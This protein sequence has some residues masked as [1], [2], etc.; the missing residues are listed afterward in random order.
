ML[1]V[2]FVIARLTNQRGLLLKGMQE[3]MKGK[4]HHAIFLVH[5]GLSLMRRDTH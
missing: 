4:L 1:S 5:Q 2:A 3:C